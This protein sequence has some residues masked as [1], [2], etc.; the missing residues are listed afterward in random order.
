MTPDRITRLGLLAA[1]ALAITLF[2]AAFV[3]LAADIADEPPPEPRPS[4]AL[5]PGVRC[6]AL[7]P[8]APL[9]TE[10]IESLVDDM[11][12]RCDDAAVDRLEVRYVEHAGATRTER[13]GVC[14]VN[15]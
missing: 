4:T 15:K 3:L 2:G 1:G 13:A 12:A 10:E 6:H 14:E 11:L 5:H 9:T 7:P 8:A